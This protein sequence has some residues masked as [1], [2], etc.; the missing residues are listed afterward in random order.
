MYRMTNLKWQK[1]TE[2]S[3]K[4]ANDKMK[5]KI[6]QNEYTVLEC[7]MLL[8]TRFQSACKV[9]YVIGCEHLFMLKSQSTIQQ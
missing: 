7:D 6:C 5:S 2:K 8:Y 1:D 4:V 9:I 3:D